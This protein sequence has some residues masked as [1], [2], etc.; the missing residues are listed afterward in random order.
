MIAGRDARGK[1]NA[2]IIE[3]KQWQKAKT[4]EGDGIVRTFLGKRERETVHPSYQA[5]FYASLIKD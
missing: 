2:M 5:S 3:L 1:K 4:C